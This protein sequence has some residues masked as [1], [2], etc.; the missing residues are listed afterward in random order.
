MSVLSGRFAHGWS[1][2]YFLV[3]VAALWAGC[4]KPTVTA[5]QEN[6]SHVG[7]IQYAYLEATQA[8]KRP[9]QN[10]EEI[11]P[12]L[13]KLGDPNELLTSPRDG[14]PYVIIWG[15]DLVNPKGSDNPIYAY[16]Q[17]GRGGER[18]VGTTLEIKAVSDAEFD[19]LKL[20]KPK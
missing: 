6:T 13:A 20:P 19:A 5:N 3:A 9:P 8:L 16:E 4:A 14:K 7:S 17:D 18:I 12:H 1:H 11:K 10:V 15:L 2:V